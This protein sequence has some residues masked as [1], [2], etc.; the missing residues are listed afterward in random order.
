MQNAKLSDNCKWSCK[1][2]NIE[3]SGDHYAK[4]E[5]SCKGR[6][7][8]TSCDHYTLCNVQLIVQGAKH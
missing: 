4:Y 5:W 7:M 8:E 3:T 6:N 1:G 2:R